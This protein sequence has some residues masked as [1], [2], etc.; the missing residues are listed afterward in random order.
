[1]TA[2]A[3]RL[4][5]YGTLTKLPGTNVQLT[6]YGNLI[7]DQGGM[8]DFSRVDG[9]TWFVQ[10]VVPSESQFVGGGDVPLTSDVG[11]WVTGAGRVNFQGSPKTAWTRLASSAA[12]GQAQIAVQDATGWQVGDEIAV[13]PTEPP[14]IANFYGHYDQR[15]IRAVSGTTVTLSA[16][17]SYDHPAVT[18]RPGV[19]YTAE[20]LNFTRTGRI[21]GRAGFRTHF[22]IHNTS[23]PAQPQIIRYVQFRYLGPQSGTRGVLG[24]YGGPHF[25]H[26][27]DFSAGSLVEGVVARNFGNHAFVPHDSDGI[28]FRNNVAHDGYESAFWYDSM[29]QTPGAMG[30]NNT[31]LES[32]VASRVGYIYRGYR[33][34]GF[35]IGAG[36]GNTARNNV[37]VGING[38]SGSAGFVWPEESHGIWTF[39]QGNLA[40]NNLV[41]GIFVW[42]NDSRDH[43]IINFTAYYNGASGIEHGAYV[44]DYLYQDITLYGNRITGFSLVARSRD[45]QPNPG[46]RIVRAYIDAGG[47][48]Y[49]LTT[50]GHLSTAAQPVYIQSSTFLNYTVAGIGVIDSAP[51]APEWLV[52]TAGS[53]SGNRYWLAS[54]IPAASLVIDNDQGL[55]VRRFDQSGTR[56]PQWNASVSP[57]AL[58]R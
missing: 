45:P 32:N 22:W 10:F 23:A 6:M 14:T 51:A 58:Q 20:V 41:D 18:V 4:L 47:T 15:T 2:V 24:R 12:A 16:A 27:M 13:A 33:L 55:Y 46:L 28:T 34:T 30:P 8:V 26:N 3:G 56:V 7:V 21:E 42:Q 39:D 36:S 53:F 35:Y 43:R 50:G 38:M 48:P 37:A 1:M 5:V 25:H 9:S 31:L 17:L 19:T 11:W 40:H 44:N 57:M 54:T 49:A 52:V 29:L